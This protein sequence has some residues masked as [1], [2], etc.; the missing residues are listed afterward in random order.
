M[1]FDVF[2]FG[3]K[4]CVRAKHLDEAV[5]LRFSSL[6]ELDYVV[7]LLCREKVVSMNSLE[8]CIDTVHAADALNET[9]GVPGNI[10]INDNVRAMEIDAFG[11][12]LRTHEDAIIIAR[13]E[14][15]GVKICRS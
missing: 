7:A 10:V 5:N 12:Y 8:L 1:R 4:P 6:L 2:A 3:E 11:Q 9:G 14:G 13:A 15:I